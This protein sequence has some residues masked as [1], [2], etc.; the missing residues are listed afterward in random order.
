MVLKRNS[1]ESLLRSHASPRARVVLCCAEVRHGRLL[2]FSLFLQRVLVLREFV[3]E[4]ARQHAHPVDFGTPD[5]EASDPR[6]WV[7]G[8]GTW[9]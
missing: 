2:A 5:P 7:S 4:H 8:L 9:A 6:K 3:D 1:R